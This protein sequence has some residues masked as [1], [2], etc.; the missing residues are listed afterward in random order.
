MALAPRW[1]RARTGV[2]VASALSAAAVVALALVVAGMALILLVG[3]SLSRSVQDDAVQQAQAIAERMHGNYG[4]RV[5]GEYTPKENAVE[6]I[7]TLVGT[8]DPALG[9]IVVDYSDEQD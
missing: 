4:K 6:A 7:D 3:R 1:L 9:Q 8:G 5:N 2:R